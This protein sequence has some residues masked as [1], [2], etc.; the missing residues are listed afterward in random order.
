MTVQEKIVHF[1][2]SKD[3]LWVLFWLSGMS[4]LWIWDSLFLNAAALDRVQTAFLHT[5]VTGLLVVLFTTLLGWMTGVGFHLMERNGSRPLYTL[6]SL[7]AD[8]IRSV[9]QI[10]IVLVGYVVLTVLVRMEILLST[11]S[12]LVWIAGTITLALF[13]EV[14]DTVRSRIEYFR[15][16]DFVDAML[17]CGISEF[18]IINIDIVWRN[19]RAHLLHKMIA[20]FGMSLFLQCSTDFI[21]SV[22]LST[23]V[24]LSNFPLTLGSLLATLDSKQDILAFSGIFFQPGYITVLLIRHLQG[25]SVAFTIIFTLLSLYKIGNGFVR[26]HKLA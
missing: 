15:S 13:L 24:S 21:V 19:S 25:L 3:R 26:R 7:L 18:R 17:C 5:C 14:A 9:P 22:G 4:I 1:Y 8:T 10:L 2:R 6:F 16:L 12:Q 11:M 20:I 23:D